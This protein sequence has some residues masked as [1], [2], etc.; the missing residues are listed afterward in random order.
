MHK[1]LLQVFFN[2]NFLRLFDMYVFAYGIFAADCNY[3][4]YLLHI[5]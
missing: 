4:I 1:F 5:H 3:D 2:T